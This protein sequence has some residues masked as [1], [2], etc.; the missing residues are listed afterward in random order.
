MGLKEWLVQNSIYIA[1]IGALVSLV[2][3]FLS[4]EKAENDGKATTKILNETKQLV[5]VNKSLTEKVDTATTANNNLSQRILE[6]TSTV[7]NL[8]NENLLISKNVKEITKFSQDYIAGKGSYCRVAYHMDND[9]IILTLQNIGSNPLRDI[10]ILLRDYREENTYK[11]EF[12]FSVLYPSFERQL[13][14]IKL[15]ENCGTIH[16]RF[17]SNAGLY[18]QSIV[19]IKK[20]NLWYTATAVWTKNNS[21]EYA[22]KDDYFPLNDVTTSDINWKNIDFN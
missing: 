4:N 19:L 17:H 18:R 11:E 6:L 16:L 9:N 22:T 13:T 1:G 10:T 7:E 2:A 14:K 15:P 21:V 12:D 8:Q 20:N 5:I 3:V